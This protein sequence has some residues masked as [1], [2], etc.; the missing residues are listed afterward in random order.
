MTQRFTLFS[1]EVEDFVLEILIDSDATF[2][3]LHR[4]IL[5][6]CGYT[7]QQ[8]HAFMVCNEDWRIEQKIRQTDT[9][10]LRSDE[11]L[12]LMD[13]TRLEEFLEDEGQ[14]LLYVFDTQE[15]RIFLMELTEN[16]FGDPV[17]EP[18]VNRRHGTAP[19]QVLDEEPE[20]TKPATPQPSTEE[21]E[22]DFYGDDGF[23]ADEL[24]AEGFEINEQ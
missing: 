9:G 1:E 2:H 11:D 24:D 10:N 15:K 7:D 16:L 8:N 19:Y 23:E 22:E 4:L 13:E 3:D 6:A 14:R 20:A 21:L 5:D 12:F 17:P 18:I